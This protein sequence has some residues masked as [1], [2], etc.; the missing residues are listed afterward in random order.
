VEKIPV[1][2]SSG[3]LFFSTLTLTNKRSNNCQEVTGDIS[4]RKKVKANASFT[5]LIATASERFIQFEIA[6]HC[7]ISV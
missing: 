7:V 6:M 5:F 3:S 4:R 1:I 2:F